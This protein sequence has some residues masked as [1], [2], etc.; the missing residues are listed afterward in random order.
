MAFAPLYDSWGGQASRRCCRL[1]PPRRLGGAI[2]AAERETLTGTFWTWSRTTLRLG[3][4]DGTERRIA[5]AM[6]ACPPAEAEP[7][8]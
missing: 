6:Y 3:L 1:A 8:C 4:S 2:S 7:C 5:V